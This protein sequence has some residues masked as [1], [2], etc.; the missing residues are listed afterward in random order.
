MKDTDTP[1]FEWKASDGSQQSF[2][3]TAAEV[4]IGRMDDT[5]LVIVH[6]H[7]SRHHAKL[8]EAS[9]GY[10]FVD[11]DSTYGTYVNGERVDRRKLQHGD[12]VRL[13]S[14]E[15]QFY[16]SSGDSNV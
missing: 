16:R 3:I 8:V 15:F 1:R 12:K 11:T 7:V 10:E 2:A 13:A 14:V 5:D 4:T 6:P 9:G